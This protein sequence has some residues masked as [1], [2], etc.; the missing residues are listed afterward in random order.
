MRLRPSFRFF[1]L[2]DQRVADVILVDIADILNGF[3]ANLARGDDLD[4][5][6]PLVGVEALTFRLRAELRYAGRSRSYTREAGEMTL[7]LDARD[8]NTG[9]LLARVT[10][11]YLGRDRGELQITDSVTNAADF[12]M[13][14]RDWAKRLRSGFKVSDFRPG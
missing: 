1:L 6:E 5:A 3:A 12:R 4:V 11:E 2:R 9:Q 13:A 10:D 7:H 8:A 14:V